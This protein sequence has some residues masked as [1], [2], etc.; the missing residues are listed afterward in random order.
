MSGTIFAPFRW[1]AGWWPRRLVLHPGGEPVELVH[2][3]DREDG[4][5][6]VV[7]LRSGARLE[8]GPEA[9]ASRLCLPAA[10]IGMCGALALAGLIAVLSVAPSPVSETARQ[11]SG[12]TFADRS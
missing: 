2:V 10:E 1:L 4:C 3:V 6:L 9:L 12:P 11:C 7:E 5:F 8:L